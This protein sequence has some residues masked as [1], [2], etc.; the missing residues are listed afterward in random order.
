MEASSNTNAMAG[1]MAPLM[2]HG[3]VAIVTGGAGGI[4]SAVSRHL[5]SLGARV[6]VAYIRD[7]APA[8][9]LVSGIND[10]TCARR[11]KS[12]GRGPSRWRRTCRTRR[13]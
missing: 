4:G 3:R 9:E 1:V 8:N 6:A 5:A 10:A 12:A 11:R 2:L 13:G 7:P